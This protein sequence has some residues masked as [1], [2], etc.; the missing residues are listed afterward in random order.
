MATIDLT[1]KEVRIL[2]KWAEMNEERSYGRGKLGS[3]RDRTELLSKL[4]IA[5]DENPETEPVENEPVETG[6]QNPEEEAAN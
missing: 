1:P 2:V 5:Q 3:L 6:V 4:Y